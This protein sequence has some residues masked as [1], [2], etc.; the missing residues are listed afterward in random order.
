MEFFRCHFIGKNL[1][2]GLLQVVEREQKLGGREVDVI[3]AGGA[4]ASKRP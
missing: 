2:C 1:D 3:S 4:V